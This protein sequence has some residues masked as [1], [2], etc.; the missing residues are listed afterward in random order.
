LAAW[1]KVRQVA[2]LCRDQGSA[3]QTIQQQRPSH[4]WRRRVHACAVAAKR[5]D[6]DAFWIDHCGRDLVALLGAGRDGFTRRFGRQHRRNPVDRERLGA[7][8]C[9]IQARTF[10]ARQSND[11]LKPTHPPPPTSAFFG[12]IAPS[13]LRR[14]CRL[15]GRSSSGGRIM[16]PPEDGV[17]MPS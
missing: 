15:A 5:R 12:K 6:A 8:V 11:V 4:R 7:Q 17:L 14:E 3:R 10:G 13:K 2:H 9:S 1:Q 16:R